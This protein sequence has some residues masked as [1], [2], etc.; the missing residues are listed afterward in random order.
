MSTIN[1]VARLAGVSSMT[2]SRVINNSGYIS[3]QTRERVERAIAE[4]GYM[5]N[6]LARQLRSKRTKTLALVLTDITNPFFTTIARGVE[7]V[8]GASGFSVMFCNTDESE[9]DEAEYLQLLIQ[10]QVDG[11]LLV[12]ASSASDSLRMLRAHKLPFV[13]IDRRMRASH[14]DEVRCDSEA[15]AYS[16]V[17]HLIDL[18]HRRIAMLTGR[19]AISTS[20][21]RIAG[22]RRA[23]A[24]AGIEPDR[25]LTLY[26]SFNYREF[27]QADG[28]S[29]AQQVLAVTPRPTAIFAANNFIAFGAM[30]A[31]REA[32]L[33]VPEDLSVVA[34]DD[35]PGEWVIEPFLTVV[36]QPAYEIGRLAADLLLERLASP[37][38]AEPRAV[39]LPTE[40]RVRRSSGPP[41]A[42]G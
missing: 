36:A 28:Y 42:E 25:R 10:R 33:R 1:D 8:A 12:P 38:P 21:D 13:V 26:G 37:K 30:R 3:R 40:L 16:A 2:V 23:L 29:M 5:P 14:V 41:P 24:E 15:G 27:N 9:A 4:L 19:K 11:V 17:R 31:L 18:G 35:L 34:F 7:D 32:G 20:A 39:I 6:A 22:Y